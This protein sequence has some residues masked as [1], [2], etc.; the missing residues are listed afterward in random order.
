MT[1]S[2]RDWPSILKRN[3]VCCDLAKTLYYAKTQVYGGS[4]H[5]DALSPDTKRIFV[6]VAEQTILQ[7]APDARPSLRVV[8]R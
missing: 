5:W 3:A 6:D 1:N 4:A 2:M 7:L 8:K